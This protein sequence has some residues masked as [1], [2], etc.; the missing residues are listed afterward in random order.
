MNDR[1]F[2]Q[3]IWDAISDALAKEGFGLGGGL[4][5]RAHGIVDRETQDIDAFRK[6]PLLSDPEAFERAEAS[7][8]ALLSGRG[9]TVEK[10]FHQDFGR[11][12][13]VTGTERDSEG[14]LLSTTI[15]L[16]RDRLPG[17]FAEIPGYGSVVNRDDM[18]GMKMR[19]LWE[20]QAERDYVDYGYD[21]GTAGSRLDALARDLP[22]V[23]DRWQRLNPAPLRPIPVLVGG[24][25]ERKTLRITAEHA[26]IWHGFGDPDTIRHKHLVLDSWCERIGRDPLAIE[27]SAGVAFSPSRVPEVSTI[28]HGAQAQAL[29]DVG[30]RLFTLSL[31]TPPYDLGPVRDVLAWRDEVNASRADAR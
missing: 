18:A 22:V 26:D 6:D 23:R 9:F 3:L 10:L 8:T 13:E 12:F 27:R 5:M 19:A 28:D 14:D 17:G 4:A 7:I 20:R 15:D 31:T 16:G 25:G 21:F 30:T 1:E 11:K 2:V 29:F 24:G